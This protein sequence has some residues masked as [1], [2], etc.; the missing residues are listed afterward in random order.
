MLGTYTQHGVLGYFQPSLRDWSRY[1]LMAG[2][3]SASD[4]QI[5]DRKKLASDLVYSYRN[6]ICGSI[7]VARH[8]GTQQAT[9]ATMARNNGTM[10]K[11]T[12]SCGRMP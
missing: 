10:V 9:I 12:M 5:A 11:V 3:F 7:L 8:A 2:L 1:A 6:A 4:V